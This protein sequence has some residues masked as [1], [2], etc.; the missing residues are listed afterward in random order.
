MERSSGGVDVWCDRAMLGV[1]HVYIAFEFSILPRNALGWRGAA[2]VVVC[3]GN[4]HPYI[5][6]D[7]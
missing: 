7:V 1:C 6:T 5:H 2:V 3:I 4:D